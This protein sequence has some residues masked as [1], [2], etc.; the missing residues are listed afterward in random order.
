MRSI[1]LAGHASKALGLLWQ[2]VLYYKD[3]FVLLQN[4]LYMEPNKDLFVFQTFSLQLNISTLRISHE[5][6]VVLL[7]SIILRDEGYG[8]K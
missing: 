3:I 5:L 6:Q 2:S 7:R 1:P 4:R 8:V